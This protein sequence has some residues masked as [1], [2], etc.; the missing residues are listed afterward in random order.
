M[1]SKSCCSPREQWRLNNASRALAIVGVSAFS[2]FLLASSA[3]AGDAPQW[4]HALV[5]A[6]LPAHDEK[7]DAVLL[8]SEDILN[9]QGNGKIKSINRRAYKI[10]RADGRHYGTIHATFDAETRITG[11]R[12]WCIPAQGKDY[13]VKDKDVIE[14]ALLGVLNGE[15]A[16]DVR[17]K[18]LQIP[19]ADPGNI[20]GYEIEHEDRPYV[21]EDEWSLQETVPVRE[22]RYT[23]QLPSG[24]EYK[25]AWMNHK[26]VTPASL[27]S[28]SWQ[29][30]VSDIEAIR[31]ENSMPP[32]HGVAGRMVVALLP[33]GSQ[34]KGFENWKEEGTWEAG[35]ERDR[36]D[37]SPELKQK[38]AQLTASSG[39]A[40]AKMR[41]LAQFV[42][43]DI[44]YVA[45]ELGIGGWQ[46]H[47]AAEIFTHKYGDCK[48]KVTLMSS[49]LGEIGVD[50][51][52]VSI[53]VDRGAVTPETPA[54]MGLF[55]HEVMA[56]HLPDSVNEP[57]FAAVMEHP[58]L[59]KLLFFDPTDE[60]TPLGQI[61]GE[62]QAN[63][64]LLVTPDGGDL[65]QLPKLA[66]ALNGIRRTAKL[67]LTSTGL[68]TGD[69]HET[70]IGDR[71]TEQRELFRSAAKDTDRVKPVETLLAHSLATFHLT[72]LN[73]GNVKE[74][75][76]PFQYN[77]SLVA[78]N[79]AKPAGDLLLVRPRVIG[80]KSSDLLETKEPRRFPVE[81]DGPSLDSDVFEI[82][83]PAGYE[84]DDLPP[85]VN[86]D[87]GFAS[88]HSKAE[89]TGNVLRY[90]RTFEVKEL[91]VPLSKIED[92]KKLYR[93]IASDE[94]NTAVL[95]AAS[96]SAKSN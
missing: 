15:L 44:R 75:E 7:T 61:R 94:R 40:Q 28:S 91:S 33:T 23:L 11:I 93:I 46:P 76:L 32:W 12:G 9:V 26:P 16:S 58:K 67:T 52:Y 41:A 20:I 5:N 55:N 47:R 95:K 63:Y 70:R 83:L 30:V 73:A 8:Y 78:E 10:L 24:W 72:K 85:P 77:Y 3:K 31:P 71:A 13:E 53:N 74:T 18:L 66:T 96:S 56:I 2:C 81:F 25:T 39:S 54:S 17:T 34:T 87:Y 21:L 79:Y 42:Q 14:T 49:M 27:G 62:L 38:V 37:P 86:A 43:Q 65:V 48:D 60:L 82:T 50:S 68:L 80:N 64:G 19:A 51:Y 22:A 29:W 45:I 4:M 92:L 69:V 36:R 6:P 90:A 88:Y 59:G 84:V 1:N 57:G 89:V 35:L